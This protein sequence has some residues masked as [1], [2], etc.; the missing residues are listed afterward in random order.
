LDILRI[1]VKMSFIRVKE[2]GKKGGKKYKY[3]YLVENRWRKRL[4][5]GKKGSRQKVSRYLGKVMKIEKQRDDDFFM[6]FDIKEVKKYLK[7]KK[8]KIVED[9]IRFELYLR[10]FEENNGYLEKKDLRYDIKKHRF[11]DGN[12]EEEKIV[13]EMNEGF[14][15]SY[16]VN[17]VIGFK[18]KHDDEHYVGIDLAKSF[19]EAGLNVPKEIFVG[20]FEKV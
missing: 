8:S 20:Y 2:I 12:G 5:G 6:Y 13:L 18:R 9:L 16:T 7:N 17:K 11:V 14:L 10:G 19:L 15:S 3:A 1:K 4:K